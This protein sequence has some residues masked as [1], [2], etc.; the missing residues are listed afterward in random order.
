MVQ[1]ESRWRCVGVQ[2]EAPQHTDGNTTISERRNRFLRD[3]YLQHS[4]SLCAANAF[5]ACPLRQV[6]SWLKL[7]SKEIQEPKALKPS[8]LEALGILTPEK[9]QSSISQSPDAVVHQVHSEVGTCHPCSDNSRTHS[10][11]IHCSWLGELKRSQQLSA[12]TKIGSQHLPK[13]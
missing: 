3:D 7:L 11:Y 4:I 13:R 2:E 6:I 5:H 10:W 1:R 12:N 9:S 8:F